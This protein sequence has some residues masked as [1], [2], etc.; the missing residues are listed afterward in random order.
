M[1]FGTIDTGSRWK[2]GSLR[3]VFVAPAGI[4]HSIDANFLVGVKYWSLENFSSRSDGNIVHL[5]N[6]QIGS[7]VL[8]I[9]MHHASS[10]TLIVQL[11]VQKYTPR[12]FQ[13]VLHPTDTTPCL[14]SATASMAPSVPMDVRLQCLGAVSCNDA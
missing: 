5:R 6:M 9:Q 4:L 2:L 14:S 8:A 12:D 3:A 7:R 13:T 11:C 1:C 10:R